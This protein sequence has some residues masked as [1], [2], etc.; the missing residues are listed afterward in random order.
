MLNVLLDVRHHV[1]AHDFTSAMMETAKIQLVLSPFSQWVTVNNGR[2][3]Q[4][5]PSGRRQTAVHFNHSKAKRRSIRLF[6]ILSM[7]ILVTLVPRPRMQWTVRRLGI[8]T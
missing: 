8:A 5:I 1:S 2:Q 4:P 6:L 3:L 7:A